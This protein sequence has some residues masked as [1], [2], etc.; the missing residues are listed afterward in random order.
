MADIYLSVCVKQASLVVI[1]TSVVKFS[2]SSTFLNLLENIWSDK[3][4]QED[5]DSLEAATVC[6]AKD[7][8]FSTS[9]QAVQLQHE[10]SVCQLFDC[11]YVSFN[12]KSARVDSRHSV[13]TPYRSAADVLMNSTR[14]KVLPVAARV[15]DV[16]ICSGCSK[17]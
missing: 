17:P 15:W 1:P 6:I 3:K 4:P 13:E 10:I 16:L 8:T 2:A 11:K 5:L 7:S 12:L 9:C 14:E